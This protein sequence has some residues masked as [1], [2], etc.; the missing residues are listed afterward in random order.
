MANINTI[1]LHVDDLLREVAQLKKDLADKRG[2]KGDQGP[3]GPAGPI[4]AAVTQ[5]TA[6]AERVAT[7]ATKRA[8]DPFE[9]QVAQL[10]RE[11]VEL[12]NE[13]KT[14][15]EKTLENA[16]VLHTVK[17]LQEYGCLD[18]KMQPINTAFLESH[19]KTLGLLK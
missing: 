6:A 16:I 9:R 7:E 18:E 3:R 2:I 13:F 11:F 4:D 15:T 1:E 19:L 12:K 10:R 14:V 5:A 8:A 17:T